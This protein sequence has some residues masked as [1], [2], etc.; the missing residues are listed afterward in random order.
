MDMIG[1]ELIGLH[2][3]LRL[4]NVQSDKNLFEMAPLKEFHHSAILGYL[5][6]RQ[7][8]GEHCNLNALLERIMPAGVD[9]TTEKVSVR[10]EYAVSYE[11]RTR[12]IDI[13]CE[14]DGKALIIENKCR[15]AGDQDRQIADYW[16][17]VK[18]LGYADQDIFVLYLP[19]LNDFQ[20]PMAASIDGLDLGSE[21]GHQLI[22]RSYRK[23][24]LPWLKDD[25]LPNTGYGAGVLVDSLKSYIDLLEGAYGERQDDKY[26]CVR[27]LADVNGAVHL[28]TEESQWGWTTSTLNAI[29]KALSNDDKRIS[30][31]ETR[32][33]VELHSYAWDV[34]SCLREKNPLLDPDN[35]IYEVYWMLRNNPTPFGARAMEYELDAGLFFGRG[36]KGS[37]WD[38]CL[39]RDH[40]GDEHVV[41]VVCDSKNL[42]DYLN[43]HTDETVLRFGIGNLAA[44]SPLL[45]KL[46]AQ[47]RWS[48]E[49]LDSGWAT[50]MVDN[51]VLEPARHAEGGAMLWTIADAIARQARAFTDRVSECC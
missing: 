6:D 9:F 11:G 29:D 19:P 24:I 16:N 28:D 46:K 15:G 21:L 23:L 43:G 12:P 30:E 31:E 35:L 22:V 3:Q 50:V 36:C 37:I 49:R 17:G 45:T 2:E 40:Q 44:D 25:V 48:V 14:F 8:R 20:M 1:N 10:C 32:K 27:R 38:S 13:L 39:Y 18:G 51:E 42:I 41:E 47:D 26:E 33:L 7:E 5:L 34:R 4:G